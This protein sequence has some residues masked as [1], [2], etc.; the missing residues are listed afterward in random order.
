[1]KNTYE[2]LLLHLD[3]IAVILELADQKVFEFVKND[4]SIWLQKNDPQQLKSYDLYVHQISHGA[5]ILGYSYLEVFM[6]DLAK[7]IYLK[8]P[9]KLPKNKN[10]TYEDLFKHDNDSNTLL[11]FIVEREVRSIFSGSMKDVLSHFRSNFQISIDDALGNKICEASLLRNCLVHAGDIVSKE[12]AAANSK[13]KQGDSIKMSAL[14]VHDYGLS[15]RKIALNIWERGKV[16]NF[17][18]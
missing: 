2:Q 8:H 3:G 15:A 4:A 17:W 12:L 1:L 16:K 7:I 9:K 5:L 13:F 11:K 14:N 10:V 6:A 18:S